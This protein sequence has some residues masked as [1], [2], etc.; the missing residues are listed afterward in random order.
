ML[1]ESFQV[2]VEAAHS[3]LDDNVNPYPSFEILSIYQKQASELLSEASD[4]IA[5]YDGFESYS[6]ALEKEVAHG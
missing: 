3:A 4:D 6:S 2:G 1:L 5:L